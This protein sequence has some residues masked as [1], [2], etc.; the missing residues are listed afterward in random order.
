[1]GAKICWPLRHERSR[2]VLCRIGSPSGGM[3]MPLGDSAG[4]GVAR[5]FDGRR[6][7]VARDSLEV[8]GGSISYDP[9]GRRFVAYC[10]CLGHGDCRRQRTAYSTVFL[11][12]GLWA[13]PTQGVRWCFVVCAITSS[14]FFQSSTCLLVGLPHIREDKS[15]A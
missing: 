8:P 14:H 12:P 7:P 3:D 13:E 1:M 4:V 5:G 15:I 9:V 10:R 6:D 11:A 2:L